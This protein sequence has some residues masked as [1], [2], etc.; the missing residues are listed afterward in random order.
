MTEDADSGVSRA[1][2]NPGPIWGS[3]PAAS[4]T[5]GPPNYATPAASTPA[6]QPQYAQPQYA[7][8]T[9]QL[10]V[11]PLPPR[12]R[13]RRVSTL[14]ASLIAGGTAFAAVLTVVVV[15]AI[16]RGSGQPSTPTPAAQP[17]EPAPTSTYESPDTTTTTTS[18]PVPPTN[19]GAVPDGYM[20]E[21]GPAG[22][23]VNVPSGWSVSDP[24]AS[25]DEADAP[26]GSGSLIRY[27]GTPSPSMSLLD[28]VGIDESG[29]A[30]VRNGYQQL[31]L[32][33]VSLHGGDDTVEWEFLFDKDGVQ[34]HALGWFWRANGHDYVVY[35]STIAS[36]WAS[37]APVV[38]AVTQSAGPV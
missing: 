32:D 8:P 11:Y 20:S 18:Q 28:A 27:G 21:T 12:R 23:Q 26:D 6:P 25:E 36:N 38:D 31:Q 34:R 24:F 9:T 5:P 17:G 35:F 15:V 29:N 37:F 3:A 2:V 16:H 22:I 1:P 30:S 10:P 13:R 33:E 7:Q 19:T 4:N 14:T